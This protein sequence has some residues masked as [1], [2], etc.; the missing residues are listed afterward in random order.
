M[1]TIETK[2]PKSRRILDLPL[3]HMQLLEHKIYDCPHKSTA[4]K[5]FWNKFSHVE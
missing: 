5:M 3:F 2:E 4:Q 1:E